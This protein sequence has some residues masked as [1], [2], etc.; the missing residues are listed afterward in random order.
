MTMRHTRR[1]AA[2]VGLGLLGLA[3]LGLFTDTGEGQIVKQPRPPIPPSPP[4]S[5]TSANLSS[6]KIIEESQWRQVV[7][8]GRDCIKDK[9]YKQAVEALQAILNEKKD[10]YV[11]VREM[12]ASGKE[13]PRWTS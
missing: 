12:D 13:I 9:E 4:S 6:V 1:W 10:H 3:L 8:V 7:N 11:Q 5:G 2:V